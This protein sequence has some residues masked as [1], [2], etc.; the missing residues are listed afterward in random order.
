MRLEVLVSTMHQESIDF[1]KKLNINSDCIIINQTDKEAYDE[2]MDKGHKIRMIST[3][4]RGLGR[5]R[6][7]GLLNSKADIILLCDDDEVL[8]DDYVEK[9][10]GEFENHPDT[11]FFIMK[12]IIYQDGKEIIKVKD[13]RE[14]KLYNSLK[15][16]S[17]HFAFKKEKIEKYNMSFS[18]YFGA[19]TDNGSGEDSLFLRDAFKNNLKVRSSTKLISKVYNDDSTWFTGYDEKHFFDKGQLAKALFPK[20][21]RLYIEYYL[22]GHENFMVDIDKKIARKKM[23]EGAKYFGG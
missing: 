5:S 6:N 8:E 18:T 20:A 21:Y 22:K 16:G 1:Y 15:Y 23:L 11:D 9:I 19:G 13:D 7:I 14:L 2:V 3:K 10:M 12:T 4:T 17:V